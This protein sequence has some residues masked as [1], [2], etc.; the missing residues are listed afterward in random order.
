MCNNMEL[1]NCVNAGFMKAQL[2]EFTGRAALGELASRPL[3]TGGTGVSPVT[4]G[5][6]GP[7][8]TGGMGISPVHIANS[9]ASCRTEIFSTT[10]MHRRRSL[11]R[12][13]APQQKWLH[14]ADADLRRF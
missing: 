5:R 9:E 10:D 11:P 13:S 1:W 3:L 4:G 2:K 7:P 6:G 12:P 14:F 8:V